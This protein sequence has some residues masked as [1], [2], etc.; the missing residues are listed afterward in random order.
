MPV[1]LRTLDCDCDQESLL[2]VNNLFHF[3]S[4]RQWRTCFI[5]KKLAFSRLEHGEG[6]GRTPERPA[7]SKGLYWPLGV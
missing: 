7:R 2:K 1:D 4:A 3:A 6:T 5:N